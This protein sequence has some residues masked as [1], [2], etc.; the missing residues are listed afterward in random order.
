MKHRKLIVLALIMLAGFADGVSHQL[1]GLG[2]GFGRSDVVF[3]VIVTLLIFVWY[4]FDADERSYRRTPFLS[5][6][7]V[8]LAALALPYY[9][10]K[11]RGWSRGS[12]A[13]GIF[14]ACCVAYVA[15]ETA[16][17]YAAY[18]AWQS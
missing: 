2:G 12:V 16:G 9:F 7:V 14:I 8:A 18:Y 3:T 1:T 15:L 6:A 5:V 13:T 10:F 4:R 11:S 17:E